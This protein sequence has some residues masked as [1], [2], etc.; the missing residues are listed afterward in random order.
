[1]DTALINNA[2]T[3]QLIGLA[4]LAIM[5]IILGARIAGTGSRGF[6]SLIME[7]AGLLVAVWIIARPNDVTGI[8]LKSVGGIQAPAMPAITQPVAPAAPAA[9]LE[10]HAT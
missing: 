6:S 2:K 10:W 8:L 1:M 5:V 3:I 4:I 7:I 9:A